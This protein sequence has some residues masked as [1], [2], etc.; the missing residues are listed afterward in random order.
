MGLDGGTF[1]KLR[2]WL[3][4]NDLPLLSKLYSG[5]CHAKLRGFFPTLSPLEWACFYTG[6]SPGKLGLFALSHVEDLKQPMVLKYGPKRLIDATSVEAMSLWKIL[7]DNGVRVGVVNI[8]A[9]YPPEKVNGFLISGYLT[10]PSASDFYYPQSLE[11]YLQGY[12]VETEF[13]YTMGSASIETGRLLAD[14]RAVAEC[15]N[16]AII[17]ILEHERINFLAVNFK[18]VD[19]LQHVFWND[20]SALL[21]FMKFV[22]QLMSNLVEVFR[23]SHII[24]M[25]DHGFHEA[26]S[27]CFY[28]NTWLRDKGMLRKAENL[29]GRFWS[30]AY[31]VAI[32][33]SE[34]SSFARRLI[35]ARARQSSVSGYA[36]SQVDVEKSEVYASQWGIFFSQQLRAKKEY[37]E[38]RKKLAQDLISL[39]SPRGSTV[40]D[41]VY[42]REEL[43]QGPYLERFPDIIPIP[44]PGFHVDPNMFHRIFGKKVDRPYLTGTHTSDAD[45][46]FILQGHGVKAGIDLGTVKLTDIAPTTLYLYDLRPPPSIDGRVI[47]EAFTS[48]F[49]STRQLKKTVA[50]DE[51]ERE[52]RVYSPEEQEEITEHLR[53]LGYI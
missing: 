30:V 4:G 43:Y 47:E 23:P 39:R 28:I 48:E 35:E 22:D 17:S 12:R 42:M 53:R 37:E 46:I 34:K 18:E 27:E 11:P 14:L 1:K 3:T 10:P 41:A 6:E 7:G 20:D 31:R 49:T 8:P 9:T 52:R 29:R 38:Y 13:E 24:I 40:F 50:S 33:L 15:R 19:T 2:P 25:S 44:S 5:G 26:A 51:E 36:S 16:K 32:W 21:K 45:G